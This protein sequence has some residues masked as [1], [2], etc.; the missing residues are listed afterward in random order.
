M[1]PGWVSGAL[2]GRMLASRR[3][4]PGS[5]HA[6]ENARGLGASLGV[7][8][9]T[10]YAHRLHPGMTLE[11]AQRQVGETTLWHLRVL[12]GW[13]PP[14]GGED[15]GVV[16][17][18]FEMHNMIDH[19]AAIALSS[20]APGPYRLGGLGTVWRKV[21]DTRT[22]EEARAILAVSDW[23]NPGEGDFLHMVR[24]VRVGWGRRLSE[25]FEDQS[26]WGA[27]YMAIELAKDLFLQPQISGRRLRWPMDKPSEMS[28]PS[29]PDLVRALP[30]E[31]SWVLKGSEDPGELWR[32]EDRWW[33]RVARDSETM[34]FDRDLGRNTVIGAS[35]ALLADCRATQGLLAAAWRR[36]SRQQEEPVNAHA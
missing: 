3:L 18:W 13:L 29:M 33:A 17:G 5:R 36:N 31:A 10:T 30:P 4:D 11:E 9:S 2:R 19:F 28:A 24:G 23:G 21:V 26:H 16:A 35:M 27:G 15:I 8:A 12:A 1:R 22:L 34:V 32:A 20:A 7:L 25:T 6:L 14:G